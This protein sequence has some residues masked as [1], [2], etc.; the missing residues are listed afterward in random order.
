MMKKGRTVE[1]K[2]SS[3]GCGRRV[4]SH[5]AT[6]EPR[7]TRVGLFSRKVSG[8]KVEPSS[9]VTRWDNFGGDGKLLRSGTFV[10]VSPL[11]L[12]IPFKLISTS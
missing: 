2:R 12:Q 7:S 5:K 9:P 3:R 4:T 1:T 10:A 6:R 11:N 8:R